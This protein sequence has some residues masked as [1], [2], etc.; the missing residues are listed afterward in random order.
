[1]RRFPTYLMFA[2]SLILAGCNHE[3]ASNKPTILATNSPNTQEPPVDTTPTEPVPQEEEANPLSL[4]IEASNGPVKSLENVPL[5]ANASGGEGAIVVSWKQTAGPDI[6]VFGTGLG[7]S[8]EFVAPFVSAPTRLDFE[9][10][11]TD[12][13]GSSVVKSVNVDVGPLESSDW[14]LGSFDFDFN[15][16]SGASPESEFVEEVPGIVMLTVRD[17]YGLEV[18]PQTRFDF[19][20]GELQDISLPVNSESLTFHVQTYTGHPDYRY[21]GECE[22]C[23]GKTIFYEDFPSAE[24]ISVPVYDNPLSAYLEFNGDTGLYDVTLKNSRLEY[25]YPNICDVKMLDFLIW[26]GPD[27]E[28]LAYAIPINKI[29]NPDEA[30]TEP[31]DGLIQFSV[32]VQEESRSLLTAEYSSWE[33]FLGHDHINENGD[34][35]VRFIYGSGDHFYVDG[36]QIY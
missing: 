4:A 36:V 28:L 2:V 6:A 13:A 27:D 12:A 29:D 14:R 5:K 11:A 32:Q 34:F 33:M 25:E 10:S 23:A 21:W 1:M 8:L 22:F 7:E 18:L 15:L 30:C 20:A 26:G 16:M 3:H 31:V 19:A 24:A 35:V 9:V 17:A